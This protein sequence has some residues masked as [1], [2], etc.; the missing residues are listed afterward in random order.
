MLIGEK[1]SHVLKYLKRFDVDINPAHLGI[2]EETFILCMQKATT[3][4]ENRYTYLHETDLNSDRLKKL[5]K[6][7]FIVDKYTAYENLYQLPIAFRANEEIRMWSHD[8]GNPFEVQS[9][10]FGSTTGIHTVY[11]DIEITDISSATLSRVSR[12]IKYGSGGYAEIVG[13]MVEGDNE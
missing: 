2:D 6:E 1:Y 4:R 9:Q 5:Y 8:N 10:L 7:L 13:K 12:C 11:N 3:M